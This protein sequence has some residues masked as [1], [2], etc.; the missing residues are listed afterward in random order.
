MP[1]GAIRLS[2]RPAA[3]YWPFKSLKEHKIQHY[4][5]SMMESEENG[6]TAS[7]GSSKKKKK[8]KERKVH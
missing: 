3:H 7:T 5:Q 8:K 1:L 4:Q 2:H 6:L